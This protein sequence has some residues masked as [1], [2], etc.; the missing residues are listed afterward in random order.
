MCPRSQLY[1]SRASLS[2]LANRQSEIGAEGFAPP[3]G[4]Y[5]VRPVYKSG[6]AAVTLRA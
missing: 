4:T 1:E 3:R 2:T 5:L 6:C